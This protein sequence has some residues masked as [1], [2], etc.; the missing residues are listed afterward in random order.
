MHISRRSRQGRFRPSPI[1]FGVGVLLAGLA[2]VTGTTPAFAGLEAKL[3]VVSDWSPGNNGTAGYCAANNVGSWDEMTSGWYDAVNDFGTVFKDGKWVNGKLRRG[4][5][6]DPDTGLTCADHERIDEA[7][8]AMIGFH[9]ADSGGHW[10]GSMRYDGTQNGYSDC[11]IDAPEAGSGEL[12]LGDA[13][14]EFYHMSSCNSMD[15]DNLVNV[16]RLF[17]DPVDSPASGKRLHLATGFHG[18]MWI[19]EGRADDY[20]TFAWAGHVGLAEAWTDTMYD[21]SVEYEGEEYQMCPIAYSVGPSLD[22]CLERLTHES[23]VNVRNPDPSSVSYWCAMA[24]EG[25]DPRADDPFVWP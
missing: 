10:R 3:Y 11:Q 21:G 14:L 17:Q 1:R 25:C 20:A 8:V 22:N 16:R 6:C 5:F 12:F 7:D 15:D 18:V 2:I 23:Y 13:D 4:L 9:G 24:Y 19:S